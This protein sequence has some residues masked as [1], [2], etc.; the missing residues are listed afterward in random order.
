MLQI[1]FKLNDINDGSERRKSPKIRR[2]YRCALDNL[3]VLQ[4]IFQ[5][6]PMHQHRSNCMLN[7][8]FSCGLY[9]KKNRLP[10]RVFVIYRKL[11]SKKKTFRQFSITNLSTFSNRFFFCQIHFVAISNDD[12]MSLFID[13]FMVL[14]RI[15]NDFYWKLFMKM[16]LKF[17]VLECLAMLTAAYDAYGGKIIE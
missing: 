5:R 2:K 13:N 6:R 11:A 10:V 9:R 3:R 7:L 17:C 14:T 8:L 12:E 4:M 1:R 15:S 16:N